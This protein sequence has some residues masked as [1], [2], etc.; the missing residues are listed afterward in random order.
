MGNVDLS[1]KG[2]GECVEGMPLTHRKFQMKL[3]STIV[4]LAA[5]IGTSL[6]TVSPTTAAYLNFNSNWIRGSTYTNG[7]GS[8]SYSFNG[9]SR[10]I[11]VAPTPSTEVIAM[12]TDI[13]ATAA[14][15]DPSPTTP[16]IDSS[17]GSLMLQ[18]SGVKQHKTRKEKA[19]GVM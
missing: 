7:F 10:R 5:V 14:I 18:Q 12:A 8:N 1:E 6:I 17:S 9:S 11:E 3:F 13:T 4:T 2:D 19:G 16:C 15:L